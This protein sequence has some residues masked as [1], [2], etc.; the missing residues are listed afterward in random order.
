[1]VQQKI[2][3][4][5]V[6]DDPGDALFVQEMLSEISDGIILEEAD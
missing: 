2:T 6:E 4:L 3:V 1:M 5:L